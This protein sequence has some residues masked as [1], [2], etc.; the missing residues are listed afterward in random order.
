M[1]IYSN[2]IVSGLVSCLLVLFF[3]TS[4]YGNISDF[5]GQVI[6]DNGVALPNVHIQNSDNDF[7]T[8]SDSEGKFL[9]PVTMD[10]EFE[11]TFHHIGFKDHSLVVRTNDFSNEPI[12][13]VL[14]PIDLLFSPVTV[15]GN[16]LL[17]AEQRVSCQSN[18]EQIA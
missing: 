14:F 9:I 18:S 13:V 15:I 12:I 8:I 7:S 5:R 1:K 11:L 2:R 10:A 6:D 17:Q 4:V 16:K 3:T